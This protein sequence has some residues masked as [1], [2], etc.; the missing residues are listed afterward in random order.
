MRMNM[1]S[2]KSWLEDDSKGYR[3]LQGVFLVIYFFINFLD[4]LAKGGRWDL[5]QHIATADRFLNGQGYFY[6]TQ[7]ASSP[8]FPGVGFLSVLVSLVA[9]PV[10]DYVLLFIASLAGTVFVYLMLKIATKYAKSS[11]VVLLFFM[12]LLFRPFGYYR[13]YMNEFKADS[14]VMVIGICLMFLIDRME[15]GSVRRNFPRWLAVMALTFVM[16]IFK[17]H[18]LYIDVGIGLYLLLARKL[19]VRE[20]FYFLSAMFVGGLLDLAVIFSI[21]GIT[22]NTMQ[23]LK[24]MPYYTIREII[25]MFIDFGVSNFYA[26]LFIF[27]S[28]VLVAA[29]ALKISSLL[30]KYLF[31]S[32]LFMLM[33]LAGAIKT[34]G[35]NGNTE[36]GLVTFMPFAALAADY[37]VVH[38]ASIKTAVLKVIA[39]TV[40]VL[41]FFGNALRLINARGSY[42]ENKKVVS[43]LSQ[44]QGEEFLYY[45]NQ[46]M[47]VFRAG[48]VPGL[49]VY[50]IP[51]NTERYYQTLE[52]SLKS[53]EYEYLLLNTAD[54]EAWE[55]YQRK[56]LNRTVNLLAPLSEN[57]DEII[58]PAMPESIQGQLFRRK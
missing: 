50:S 14:I 1:K 12:V 49:D 21:P 13:S 26:C 51:W 39:V 46:Y 45:S 41:P 43:Y 27:C 24:D 57:Y 20:K 38:Y 23:D 29:K 48:I 56:Y 17:Q 47:N 4:G 10:R 52:N 5:Y 36:S 15:D 9:A 22:I 2:I 3:L 35:N 40:C 44:F 28:M 25:L 42:L 30:K 34:G 31:V 16:G 7:L 8:Y 11:F 37:L 55:K 6:S 53:R 19:S 18:A 33:Q 32:C 58:D 54:L